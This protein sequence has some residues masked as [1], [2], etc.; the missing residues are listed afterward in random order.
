M[1]PA[2]LALIQSGTAKKGDV[3]GIARIAGIQAAKK[4]SELIP[5]A[6]LFALDARGRR[7]C[8][9]MKTAHAVQCTATVETV[10]SNGRGNGSPHRG[11]S[12]FADHL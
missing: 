4:T 10:G 12:G 8:F 9:A 11:A 6:T 5:C 2:T 7:V 1:L 3:L